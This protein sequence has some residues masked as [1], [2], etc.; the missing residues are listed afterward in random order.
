[1]PPPADT[2]A[3]QRHKGPIE[4]PL[5]VLAWS[6]PPGLRGKDAIAQFA[7]SRLNLALGEGLDMR[8]EDDIMGAGAGVAGRWPTP[9]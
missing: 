6:L 5:L 2:R 8:E 7:A 1:M 4:Q 9:R 3:L